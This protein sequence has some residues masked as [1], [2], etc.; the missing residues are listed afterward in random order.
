MSMQRRVLAFDL[1][2][3][4]AVTKSPISDSIAA[5]LG[6]ALDQ[7]EVCVISGGAFPQFQKQVI[8]RLTVAPGRF[9]RLH[10]MPTS[11]TRYVRFDEATSAWVQQYAEDL[12][13]AEKQSIIEVL[14]EGARHLGLWETEPHGDIIEDRGSQITFSALGQQAP[15]ELKYAWDGDGAKK[16]ALREYAAERLPNLSVR[17]GGSTS[18]DVT[19]QGIDKAYGMRR[20]LDVLHLAPSDVLFFGD[21]L[22]EG[23]NDFPVKSTGIETIAVRDAGDTEVALQVILAVSTSLVADGGTR[24]ATEKDFASG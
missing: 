2:D 10:L 6:R 23:G 11:G 17:A 16:K 20:L 24:S 13:T 3:T 15:P 8:D 9:A 12:S 4:L 14:I 21:Q 1:D 19:R 5:L 7:Y 22:G 18:V